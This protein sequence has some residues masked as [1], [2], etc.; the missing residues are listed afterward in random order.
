ME[1]V[2][3]DETIAEMAD[4]RRFNE[5]LG[6]NRFRQHE[7]RQLARE[8]ARLLKGSDC[9]NAVKAGLDGT[10]TWR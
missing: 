9:E 2:P 10:L 6:G 1:R 8:V 7:Y 5:M 3:E 4:A